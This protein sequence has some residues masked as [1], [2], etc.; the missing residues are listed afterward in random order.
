[1]FPPQAQ[2][3]SSVPE[4]LF[5]TSLSLFGGAVLSEIQKDFI[6]TV[7]LSTH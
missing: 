5:N 2:A 6:K 1:M 4:T 3:L 7:C